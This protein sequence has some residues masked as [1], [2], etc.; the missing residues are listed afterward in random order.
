MTSFIARFPS[1]LRWLLLPVASVGT[2]IVVTIVVGIVGSL[3]DFLSRSPWG[4]NFS[5]HVVAP[6]VAGYCSV[7]ALAV[8]A[9]S[10]QGRTALVGTAL[11]MFVFG[12]LTYF[13]FLNPGWGS[14][15][16]VVFSIFG[17]VS[18]LAASYELN[19]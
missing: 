3:L 19:R 12:A 16:P 13:A 14:F 2:Y 10:A 7:L 1:W 8:V 6:G 5:T 4:S 15:L 17:A 18:G 11:W 9:P